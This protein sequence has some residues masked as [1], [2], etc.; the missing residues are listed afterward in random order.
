MSPTEWWTRLGR[1]WLVVALMVAN[2]W[3]VAT[4]RSFV[5]LTYPRPAAAGLVAFCALVLVLAWRR[6]SARRDRF[7]FVEILA[8]AATLLLTL[9]V[10]V[11]VS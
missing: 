8:M 1:Y 2:V 6:D 7:T 11:A 4:G 10:G 9:I 5:L 3:I